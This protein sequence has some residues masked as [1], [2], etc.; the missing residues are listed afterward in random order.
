MKISPLFS[1]KFRILRKIFKILPFPEKFLDF[2]PPK[3]LM[4]SPYFD[5]FPPCFTQIHLLLTYFTCI[6]FA[7]YFYHDAFMHHPMHVL[8]PGDPSPPR[9][10]L[11]TNVEITIKVNGHI[12]IASRLLLATSL[13][14][15]FYL[16]G[17]HRCQVSV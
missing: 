16:L 10:T 4:I 9:F 17:Q 12:R 1:K 15:L 3:F 2:H 11:P 6:S 14:R 7:P 13:A 8:F 5:K